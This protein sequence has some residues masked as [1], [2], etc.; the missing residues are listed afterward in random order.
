MSDV[1]QRI[2]ATKRDEVAA[3][4][5]AEPLAALRARAE[6]SV[7]TD[8]PR[9]FVGALRAAIAAGRAAVIAEI[10]K[11]SPSKGVLRADF[12]PAAIAASYARAGAACLSVLT[13]EPYF[14]GHPTYLGQARAAAALPALRKDFIVEAYQ[15]W[16]A[17]AWGA[18]AILL[19]A[20]CLDDAQMADFEAIAHELGMAV[21]VEVHD[22]A[23]LERALRLR[24][25]LVGINNRNLR[26]FEVS[27]DTT[28]ALRPQVPTDRLLVTE[29]GILA[30]ADVQRMR[31]A[32]VHAFLVG[33][34]FM[35]APDPGGALQA[36]F[37][38]P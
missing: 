32:G 12:D 16:Q 35:R 30:P 17:R 28:L 25:P 19:I 8:P 15:V 14:Q 10:K 6:A 23:E 29:S 31:D 5:R 22:S 2:C 1:L 18:D 24:T 3:A 36:L 34:A 4:R 37:G 13:D 7:R 21:L 11:A 20:A 27:L 33:E 38:A 9:D 26:T